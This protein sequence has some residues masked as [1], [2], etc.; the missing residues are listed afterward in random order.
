[1]GDWKGAPE[2]HIDRGPRGTKKKLDIVCRRSKNI[3]AQCS[4]T[5]TI[6]V[7]IW[8]SVYCQKYISCQ[9]SVCTD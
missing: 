3:S 6:F 7:R 2:D 4:F 5:S 9:S 8:K 1:M